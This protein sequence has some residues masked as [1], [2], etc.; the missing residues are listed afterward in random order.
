M[1]TISLIHF[2]LFDIKIGFALWTVNHNCL[3]SMELP[4]LIIF[5]F[6]L[7]RVKCFGDFLSGLGKPK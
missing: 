7:G 3:R 4:P 6:Y 5:R 2:I 1:K